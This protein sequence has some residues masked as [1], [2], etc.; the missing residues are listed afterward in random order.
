MGQKTKDTL[1]SYLNPAIQVRKRVSV[2]KKNHYDLPGHFLN[3]SSQM[4]NALKSGGESLEDT[5]ILSPV[6]VQRK[7]AERD[8]EENKKEKPIKKA[9][10]EENISNSELSEGSNKSF[11][12]KD[13]SDYELKGDHELGEDEIGSSSYSDLDSF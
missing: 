4:L 1:D 10:I 7:K 11:E 8:E 3:D 6:H 5:E 9:S 2:S 12:E 13:V